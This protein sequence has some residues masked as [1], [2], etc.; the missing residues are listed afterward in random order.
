MSESNIAKFNAMMS[1]SSSSATSSDSNGSMTVCVRVR[2]LSNQH[3]SKARQKTTGQLKEV[4]RV[5]KVMAAVQVQRL[6]KPGAVLRSERAAQWN[7]EF[8]SAFGGDSQQLS[9]YEATTKPLISK[10][11][12]G[13]NCTVFAYGATG[14][15]KTHTMTGVEDDPNHQ[16]IIPRALQDIFTGVDHNR[17]KAQETFDAKLAEDDEMANDGKIVEEGVSDTQ[18]KRAR[19]R[20]AFAQPEERRADEWAVRVSY[21][22]VYNEKCY[23]LLTPVPTG[24]GETRKSLEPREDPRLGIVKV[25]GLREVE[26]STREDVLALIAKGSTRRTME[27]TAANAVSSRSHAVLQ[28]TVSSTRYFSQGRKHVTTGT[29]SLID[30]AGSERASATDNRGQRLTEGANIN[31]SLLALANCINAL[32]SKSSAPCTKKSKNGAK[33]SRKGRRSSICGPISSSSCSSNGPRVKYRDSKL[34]HLLKSSL[35]GN[36]HL[37]MIACVNPSHT[38]FEESHNTLKY[39]NRAKNIKIKPEKHI[40]AFSPSIAEKRDQQ[41]KRKKEMERLEQ[42]EKSKQLKIEAQLK[43]EARKAADMERRRELANAREKLK[44]EAQ[45]VR[46]KSIKERKRQTL[47]KNNMK[48]VKKQAW[49]DDTNTNTSVHSSSSS[50]SSS[51]SIQEDEDLSTST[52]TASS[53]NDEEEDM[54]SSAMLDMSFDFN[55]SPIHSNSIVDDSMVMDDEEGGEEEVSIIDE[56]RDEDQNKKN[57][58]DR[59]KVHFI[60][61][62][63][64]NESSDS[65]SRKRPRRLPP[66]KPPSIAALQARVLEL[67][68]LVSS[69]EEDKSQMALEISKLKAELV[70]SEASCKKT[71]RHG[72][73]KRAFGTDLAANTMKKS[74]STATTRTSSSS[75]SSALSSS[76]ST[77]ASTSALP[78]ASQP[79]NNTRKRRK[80]RHSLIPRPKSTFR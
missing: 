73:V 74:S 55:T 23:D 10:V 53:G 75:S 20:S 34:T 47:L 14:A 13:L 27:S 44:K 45:D 32:S 8:D 2:P 15:G 64:L 4:V 29:M 18:N 54:P 7:Y 33:R 11:L 41:K 63:N 77:S 79:K 40:E 68:L 65:Q 46:L 60:D 52:A 12:S 39:A 48:N 71:K 80:R 56:S 49:S 61:N 30:L 78:K 5:S 19:L 26:V 17:Q 37:V 51:S 57:Q 50:S 9:V 58:D 28:V 72:G 35:E 3:E 67:E 62:A 21:L 42:I 24:E 69:L 76:S 59:F 6:A 31:K 66:A 1:S 70:V 43:M 16:G 36:C 25:A 38:C 22:E